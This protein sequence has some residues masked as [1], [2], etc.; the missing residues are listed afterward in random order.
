MKKIVVWVVSL[1]YILNAQTTIVENS[2]LEKILKNIDRL[3]RV[4]NVLDLKSEE[5]F[6]YFDRKEAFGTAKEFIDTDFNLN[7]NSPKY[8]IYLFY[9]EFLSKHIQDSNRTLFNS[10]NLKRLNFVYRYFVGEERDRYFDSIF[11]IIF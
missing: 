1:F 9:K 2:S 7:K 8:K 11:S 5:T 3:D 10:I 4:P 6:F